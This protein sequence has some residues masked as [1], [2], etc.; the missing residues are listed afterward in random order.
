MDVN[1]CFIRSC[2]KLC[3]GLSLTVFT[4]NIGV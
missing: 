2:I 3:K 4:V 1:V